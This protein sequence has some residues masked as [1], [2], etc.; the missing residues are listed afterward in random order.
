MPDTPT[1]SR[2]E[3]SDGLIDRIL[4]ELRGP[5]GNKLPDAAQT[6]FRELLSAILLRSYRAYSLEKLFGHFNSEPLGVVKDAIEK[7][8]LEMSFD[9]VSAFAARNGYRPIE[10]VRGNRVKRGQPGIRTGEQFFDLIWGDQPHGSMSRER[11]D[12][13][14][15][16]QQYHRISE[17]LG[18]L[19]GPTRGMRQEFEQTLAYRFFQSQTV[20]SYPG[21][22][23]TFASTS[24]PAN[25]GGQRPRKVWYHQTPLLSE[26]VSIE[27]LK[28]VV[29]CNENP[30]ILDDTPEYWKPRRPLPKEIRCI[31]SW[32]GMKSYCR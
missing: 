31:T 4:Q 11:W 20:F 6:F 2:P 8:N 19:P 32:E 30:A 26:E 5:K 22:N 15:F 9:A 3:D 7:D 28:R 12:Q 24:K 25:Q 17:E 18:K 10:T 23:G 27:A 21:T 1:A 16:R 29:R 13:A 14:V